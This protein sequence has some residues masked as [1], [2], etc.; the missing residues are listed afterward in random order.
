MPK[1]FNDDFKN[2]IVELYKSGKGPTELAR[3]YGVS[4]QSVH[5]WIGKTKEI[6]LNDETITPEDI[7]SLKKEI[8]RLKEENEIL[9]K[10]TAIFAKR[11]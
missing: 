1:K 8:S 4:V 6:K 2:T 5:Q 7:I 10:A 9:K 11:N 3:E